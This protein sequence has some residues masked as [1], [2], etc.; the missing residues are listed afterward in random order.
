[1]IT[2][3]G[4]PSVSRPGKGFI[5]QQYDEM[6]KAGQLTAVLRIDRPISIP[7]DGNATVETDKGD[8]GHS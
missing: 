5:T 3:N 2:V 7:G 1:M 6:V 4:R 8:R